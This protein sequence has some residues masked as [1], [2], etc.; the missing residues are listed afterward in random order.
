MSGESITNLPRSDDT[1]S[2]SLINL[3]PV[4][5]VKIKGNCLIN[6]NISVFRTVINLYIS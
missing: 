1:S 4:S 6:S 2:P 5:N 3:Y